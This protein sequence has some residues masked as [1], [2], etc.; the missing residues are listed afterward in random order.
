MVTA[1]GSVLVRCDAS[2]EI[3]LG[4]LTRCR[5]LA[6]ALERHGIE[7]GFAV[8]QQPPSVPEL[9]AHSGFDAITVPVESPLGPA[10]L[11]AT[12]AAARRRKADCVLVDHYEAGSR[13][14]D[15][16][17]AAGLVVAVVD[18]RAD[19]DLTAADW[20][21]NQNLAAPDL[22]YRTV[23]GCE[24][25]LGVSYAL[26]RP[27]FTAAHWE[28]DRAFSPEDRRV[29]VTLGGG[30]TVEP[31]VAVVRALDRVDRPLEVRVVVGASVSAEPVRAVAAASRQQVAVLQSVEDMAEQMVWAD[32]SVNAGGSTC[33]ELACLGVPMVVTGL[34]DDQR[35]NPEPLAQ[36]G[37][38]VAIDRTELAGV[39]RIIAGLLDD[40][41]R[42][43]RMSERATTLVDGEGAA[44]AAVSLAALLER[45]RAYAER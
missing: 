17:R 33:W 18:D 15:E 10:D 4:H 34:S 19:R 8:R 45:G 36:A 38:A 37:V 16:I 12:L 28:L 20:L 23:P 27:E 39:G 1:Q 11:A 41:A 25:L 22:V 5:A 2:P 13:Y 29:L 42:R 26:L 30:D 21:L 32:L 43:K 35:L 24:L 31:A 3:G 40:P 14:F 9:L 44:R 7:V 6:K